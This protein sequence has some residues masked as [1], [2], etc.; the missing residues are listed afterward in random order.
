MNTAAATTVLKQTAP[1]ILTQAGQGFWGWLGARRARKFAKEA[2]TTAYQR[3][4]EMWQN[5]NKYNA[6]DQQMQRLKDA[7]LNPN[8]V[9][10]NGSVTGN[11]STATPKH[12]NYEQ[13]VHTSSFPNLLNVLSQYQDIKGKKLSND[14]QSIQNQ[15]MENLQHANLSKA[16]TDAIRGM[17]ETN[18]DKKGQD[19]LWTRDKSPYLQQYQQQVKSKE[20]DNQLKKINVDFMKT[21]PKEY[22][23]LIPLLL[24]II[25]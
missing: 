10:G 9:Y 22:Q 12:Q 4:V 23:F 7:N 3:D 6:P 5:A 20:L 18:A 1:A 16:Q 8:L 11:T 24:R 17:Q 14:A 15:F 25:K 2:A 19:M 21:I 13:P